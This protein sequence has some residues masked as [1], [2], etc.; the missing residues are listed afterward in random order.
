MPYVQLSLHDLSQLVVMQTLSGKSRDEIV[1][2]LVARGWPEASAVRFVNM[3]LNEEAQRST[4]THEPEADERPANQTF[5]PDW[6]SWRVIV[7]MVLVTAMFIVCLLA[8]Y[9]R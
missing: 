1:K 5:S 9:A 7:V 8:G 3:T 2:V 4:R 6:E